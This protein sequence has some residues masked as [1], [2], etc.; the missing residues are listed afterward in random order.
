M[1]SVKLTKMLRGLSVVFTL[2]SSAW[3]QLGVP[4]SDPVPLNT[5]AATDSG[6]DWEAQLT[7]DGAG[8]W[9][10]VW[11]SNEDLG[12]TIGADMDVLVSR[13][14]DNGL[15]WS[16]PAPLN[17]NAA[18]DNGDDIVPQVATDGAG[19]WVAVWSSGPFMAPGDYDILVARSADNGATWSAPAPLN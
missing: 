19:H 5:N 12:G 7:T 1:P 18:A 15:T 10:A 14:T 6:L 16:A 13:S 8:H 2:V 4:I 3:A 11:Y 9:L 17:T